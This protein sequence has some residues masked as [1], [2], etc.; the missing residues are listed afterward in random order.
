MFNVELAAQRINGVVIGPGDTFSFNDE[1]G[2]VS[3]RSGYKKGYGISQDGDD[4]VTIPSEGG[5]I[6][7]VATTLFQSVFWAGYPIVERNWHLYWI[8][9]YGQR[10]RGLK[11]LDATI[12]Q[13][14]DQD[15]K[16]LYAV[17][18]RWRN[19]TEAPVLIVAET[20]RQGDRGL[21]ARAPAALAGQGR[22]AEDRARRQGRHQGG[23]PARPVAAE[24]RRAD[25]RAR[26]GR[27]PGH[28][29]AL[30]LRRREADRRDP[31]GLDLPP[32]AQRLPGRRRG[33]RA[34]AR[35]SRIARPRPASAADPAAERDNA[36]RLARSADRDA[37]PP[38]TATPPPPPRR[39]HVRRPPA[40]AAPADR[41]ARAHAPTPLRTAGVLQRQP[42]ADPDASSGRSAPA[43]C[44]GFWQTTIRRPPS[45]AWTSRRC[46]PAL[47]TTRKPSRDHLRVDL[48]RL[49]APERA[50]APVDPLD[51]LDRDLV[52]RH[53]E[54]PRRLGRARP[55]RSDPASSRSPP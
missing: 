43:Y 15:G 47:T 1:V 6:C 4:V 50:V 11:G 3:Y 49:A 19:N 35:G 28:D 30:D 46:P 40:A 45:S 39:A 10:P 37:A 31:A 54:R 16:L 23:P 25:G 38:A 44:V 9:R 14:Y 24:R 36:V 8:P 48:A 7:Q 55:A 17:D 20:E 27:L 12:D 21:A 34:A 29:R 53:V 5:G 22:R 32:V 13:V 51:P 18:L 33:A 41:A 2:E 42:R 52:D 26:R